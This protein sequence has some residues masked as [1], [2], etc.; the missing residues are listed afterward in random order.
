M[1]ILVISQYFYPENFRINDFVESLH[2]RGH[3]ITVLTAIPNYP[4]GKS[5][6]EYKIFKDNYKNI[7]LVRVPIFVRGKNK[8][9][10]FINYVSFFISSVILYPIF[11]GFK[12]FDYILCPLYSPPTNG[13]IGL[14]STLFSKAKLCIWVQDLWPESLDL[15]TKRTPKFI[16]EII[17]KLMMILYKNSSL[18][19]VQSQMFFEEIKNYGVNDEKIKYL[20]N[21]AEDIFS[22]DDFEISEVHKPVK[23]ILFAGNIGEAQNMEFIVE[24]IDRMQNN[25]LVWVF[26]GDGSKYNWLRNTIEKKK[27]N[28]CVKILGRKPLE[29]MPNLFKKNS[30]MLV[31][32]KHDEKINKTLPGKVQSYMLC[33]KPIVGIIGGE[34]KRVIEAS[35]SGIVLDV[36]DTESSIASLTNFINLS[37]SDH[38]QMGL[39]GYQYYKNHFNK[40]VL[41]KRFLDNLS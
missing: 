19:F 17:K 15:T 18:I 26:A 10:L 40:D 2:A 12:R 5:F 35:K 32:L 34:G 14:I 4:T 27:L 41:I 31:S 20:P 1:K 6:G 29:E 39:N 28:H 23:S 7:D 37:D 21:W 33:K 24:L 36:N 16:S 8:F 11:F 25:K 22:K 3:K 9:T 13:F 38:S 30:F